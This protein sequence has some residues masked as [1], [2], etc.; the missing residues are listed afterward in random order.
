MTMSDMAY[1]NNAV[2]LTIDAYISKNF[3][4]ENENENESNSNRDSNSNSKNRNVNR[5]EDEDDKNRVKNISNSINGY[6]IETSNRNS[7]SGSEGEEKEEEEEDEDD[8]NILS[9][10]DQ[11]K[12]SFDSWNAAPH[13]PYQQVSKRKTMNIIC[14]YRSKCNKMKSNNI[15]VAVLDTT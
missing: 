8:S 7:N 10:T 6:D 5:N 13:T 4:N 15:I 2:H 12:S 1:N 11:R 14:Y 3:E 9:F